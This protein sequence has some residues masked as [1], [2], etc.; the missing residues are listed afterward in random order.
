M[1]FGFGVGDVLM[2]AKAI[3]TTVKNIRDAPAELRQ[4]AARV[5]AVDGILQICDA[6]S[7]QQP[8]DVIGDH[9]L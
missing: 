1:S 3:I 6:A 5:K 7:K 8:Q 9:G 4:L 2:I